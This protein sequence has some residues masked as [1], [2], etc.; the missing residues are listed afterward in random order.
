M[1]N[2]VIFPH[3]AV[4]YQSATVTSQ[5]K[6]I[7]FVL[8]GYGQLAQY[9]IR[10]FK[11][12]STDNRVIIAPGG[13]SRF[14]LDGF[15]GRVGSTWM[16]KE[17]RLLDIDNYI[18]YLN[19]VAD[20]I[21]QEASNDIKITLL[22]FSQGSATVCRW[23]EKLTFPFDRLI[24]HSGA[25]PPDIDFTGLGDKLKAKEVFMLRGNE[26]EFINEERK[27]DQRS[28]IEKLSVDVKEIEFEGKHDIHIDSLK[29]IIGH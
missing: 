15:S 19:S 16:T 10:K 29:Q 20:E 1:R 17:E 18:K 28:L 24:L 6:E 8:H 11:A 12:I 27:K 13:L 14:Y 4:F 26:D 2:T 5:T 22:G 9:F 25:F 7:W 21:L 3:E 23:V